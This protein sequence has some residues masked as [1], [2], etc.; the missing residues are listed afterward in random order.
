MKVIVCENY[1]EMSDKGAAL[2]AAEVRQNPEAVL[3]LATGS[4]PIGMYSR[5][6]AAY[7]RGELDFSKVKTY[8]LDEY[9]P[10]DPANKNS[11]CAFMHEHLW[12]KVN[13]KPENCHIPNGNIALEDAEAQCAAYDDA[14]KAAGGIDLQLLGIGR[15]G[16]I[17]FNEPAESLSVGTHPVKLTESTLAANGP[18]F[19]DPSEMPRHAVTMGMGSI[20]SAKKILIIANGKAKHDAIKGL[21][22]GGITTALPASILLLHPDVTLICDKEAYNG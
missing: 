5:L 1:E 13:L 9:L 10:I 4:S 7:E 15:N 22:N 14:I 11:Y 8:N 18:L 21:L 20:F 6:V 17:G 2:I 19:D 12:D 3:G 16:H